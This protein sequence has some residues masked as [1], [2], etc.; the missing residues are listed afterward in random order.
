[1]LEH[2]VDRRS[3][4]TETRRGYQLF[5]GELSRSYSFSSE[6]VLPLSSR[7]QLSF[8]FPVS[9]LYISVELTQRQTLLQL[10]SSLIG[11]TSVM[12]GFKV[13][14][15]MFE[16][17]HAVKKTISGRLTPQSTASKNFALPQVSSPQTSPNFSSPTSNPIF[18][19]SRAS[20][21]YSPYPS[22]PKVAVS[23]PPVQS[24]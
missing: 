1:M 14:F 22:A 6:G 15:Q 19:A 16:R 10:F 24:H 17:G 12:G 3:S 5:T 11:V 8:V 23:F 20:T 13:L 21:H 18:S 4:L 2:V 7:V 9:E